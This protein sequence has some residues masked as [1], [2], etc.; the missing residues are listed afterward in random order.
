M[1]LYCF[2]CYAFMF[3]KSAELVRLLNENAELRCET[4]LATARISDLL[5]ELEVV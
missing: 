3:S 5:V 1:F 4:S 2:E